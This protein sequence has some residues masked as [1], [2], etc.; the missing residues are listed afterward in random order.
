MERKTGMREAM[1]APV[2]LLDG[3]PPGEGKKLSCRVF[4]EGQREERP[5][6]LDQISEILQE[7]DS[8]VWLDVVDPGP[9]D[10]TLIEEEFDLH[11]LAVEDAIHAHQRP[12]IEAYN[13]YWFLVVQAVTVVAA[14]FNFH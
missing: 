10:L 8:L 4:R 6:D 12:K 13:S 5:R 2:D 9:N 14:E 11:P 3:R 1:S 7:E